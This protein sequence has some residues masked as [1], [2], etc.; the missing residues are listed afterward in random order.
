MEFKASDCHPLTLGRAI[1][2]F[3]I[4]NIAL[5]AHQQRVVGSAALGIHSHAW[6]AAD[7]IVLLVAGECGSL[8]DASGE[9]IAWRLDGAG[10]A[11]AARES[12]LIRY[13]WDFL[14]ANEAWVGSLGESIIDG[15]VHPL[16]VV[17]GLIHVGEG[18]RILPGV[19]IEGNVVIGRN[20]KIGP[21]CY[22]RGNTSIGDGCHIGQSVEI[23]NTIVLDRSSIGH[24]SYVGDS[25]LGEGVNFG[26]GTTTSN[27]ARSSAMA[28]IPASTPQFIP[29]AKCGRVSPLC[30]ALSCNTM[31]IR[32]LEI[33]N[34]IISPQKSCA[35]SSDTLAKRRRPRC[36][37]MACVGLSIAATIR[38]ASR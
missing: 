33:S 7:E 24:L 38:Q 31:S 30:R 12:F 36:S 10:D 28:C 34:Q 1:G 25:V 11:I 21:N 5:S 35:E 13:P 2:D 37:S 19:F 22:I 17:E 8:L 9:K 32:S 29:A 18:T 3:P 6:L 20:C 14:R 27:L 16:A 4:G 23:K 15:E 26:A